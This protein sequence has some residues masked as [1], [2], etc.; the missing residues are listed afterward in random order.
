MAHRTMAFGPQDSLWIR[1]FSSRGAVEINMVNPSL[2]PNYQAPC[3]WLGLAQTVTMHPVIA[4][5]PRPALFLHGQMG[6]NLFPSPPP[7]PTAASWEPGPVCPMH[8]VRPQL[9][10]PFILDHAQW[11]DPAHRQ[12]DLALSIQPMGQNV[13]VAGCPSISLTQ[14]PTSS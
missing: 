9:H 4:M 14:E 12:M 13:G 11:L 5:Q 6:A 8:Q 3:G 7:P 1:K 10:P 2:L